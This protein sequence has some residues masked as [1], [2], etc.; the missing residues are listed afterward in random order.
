MFLI[1]HLKKGLWVL[2]VIGK[3]SFAMVTIGKNIA[4]KLM[5]KIEILPIMIG[6]LEG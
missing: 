3:G 5:N 1:Y 6:G 4:N 2:P